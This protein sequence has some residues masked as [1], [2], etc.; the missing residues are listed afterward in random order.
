MPK[1]QCEKHGAQEAAEIPFSDPKSFMCSVC[2]VE[3]LPLH[4]HWPETHYSPE[5]ARRM[6]AKMNEMNANPYAAGQAPGRRRKR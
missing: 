6:R 3:A 4:P 5:G 1:I 2:F